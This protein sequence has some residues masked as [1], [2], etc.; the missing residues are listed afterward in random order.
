MG[1]PRNFV[2]SPMCLRRQ[3][4]IVLYLTRTVNYLRS[5]SRWETCL[6][7]ERTIVRVDSYWWRTLWRT[8]VATLKQIHGMGTRRYV[9]S[10]DNDNEFRSRCE[11]IW[12]RLFRS[13]T[14]V[15]FTTTT[16]EKLIKNRE[17]SWFLQKKKILVWCDD[18]R[19]IR[20]FLSLQDVWITT[21]THIAFRLFPIS[22]WY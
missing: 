5:R 13:T 16:V 2:T 11:W 10:V 8:C 1:I 15:C 19:R 4:K 18:P 12:V 17:K 9:L 22:R 20:W 6:P 3:L 14:C 21:T 7:F